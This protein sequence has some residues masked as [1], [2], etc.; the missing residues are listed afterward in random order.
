M[1]ENIKYYENSLIPILKKK[2]YD[3]QTLIPELEAN[4]IFLR[5]RV[6]ELEAENSKLKS[7]S[8]NSDTYE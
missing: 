4:I 3:S 5:N 6:S 2:L 1:E 7:V 8:P